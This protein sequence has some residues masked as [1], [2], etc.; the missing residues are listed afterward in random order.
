MKTDSIL[1]RSVFNSLLTV[2]VIAMVSATLGMVVDSVFT[3]QF[4]GRDAVAAAGL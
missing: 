1:T 2:N 3:G 4:L